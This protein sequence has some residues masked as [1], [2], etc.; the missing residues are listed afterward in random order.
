M[1]RN[2]NVGKETKS[3]DWLMSTDIEIFNEIQHS[4]IYLEYT[5]KVSSMWT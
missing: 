2:F 5:K 3:T 1:K 4:A